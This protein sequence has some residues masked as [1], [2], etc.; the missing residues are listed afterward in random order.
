VRIVIQRKKQKS[1]FTVGARVLAG[2]GGELLMEAALAAA[3]H[4]YLRLSEGIKLAAR[5][6]GKDVRKLS[7]CAA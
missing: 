5:S 3:F 7:C 1:R 6:F 4:P 2:E